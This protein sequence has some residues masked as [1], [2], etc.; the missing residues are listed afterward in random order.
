M[1]DMPHP[2]SPMAGEFARI[3]EALT[4]SLSDSM[5][6]RLAS[7]GSNALEVVD[8]LN[9]TDVRE[10]LMAVLD[11]VGTMHRS[12]ALQTVIDTLF[13]IHAVRSA[14]S[15][16]MVDRAF[17]FIEHMAN[18]LGTEDLATLAHEAKGAMEDALDQTGAPGSGGGLMGTLKLLSKPE[19]QNAL[20]FM[21]AFS[22]SLRKR[23]Q[24]IAK[25]PPA[26]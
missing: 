14:A 4:Q 7:T 8:K 2:V 23:A 5:V 3:G 19:T 16:S 9:E 17:Q 24:V 15:D 6:E 18:N 22:C 25:T 20:R 21:L 11:A 13:L 10:G 26:L 12:G 1:T